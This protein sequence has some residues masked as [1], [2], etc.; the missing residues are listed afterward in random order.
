MSAKKHGHS[1]AGETL[2]HMADVSRAWEGLLE[3]KQVLQRIENKMDAKCLHRT[4]AQTIR[5]RRLLERDSFSGRDSCSSSIINNPTFGAEQKGSWRKDE[6]FTLDRLPDRHVI[7]FSSITDLKL[8]YSG[9]N[10]P[11]DSRLLADHPGYPS[12]IGRIKTQDFCPNV[13]QDGILVERSVQMGDEVPFERLSGAF[14]SHRSTEDM[15]EDVPNPYLVVSSPLGSEYPVENYVHGSLVVAPIPHLSPKLDFYSQKLDCLKRNSPNGKLEKLKERIRE[16]KRRLNALK[17]KPP[18]SWQTTGIMGKHVLKR[19]VAFAPPPHTYKD[20]DRLFTRDNDR[21][22]TPDNDRLFTRDND[23]LFTPDN[24]RL[25]T[26]DIDR[27]FSRDNDRLFTPDNNRLFTRDNDRLFSRDNDRLFTR[28]NDRLFSR[29]NDRLFTRD[30]DRL[31]TRD[32]D[33]LFTRDNDRLFT[34]DI[35]RLFTRDND[36][37]FTRDI[38]RL[39]TRDNDRL[40]TRDI[41]R[42]FTRDIDRLFTRDIDRLFTR[43]NDRLFTRD[44]DRLFTRDIDR[45]F[46]RDNDRLFTRDN[47]KLFTRDN[48]VGRT[49]LGGLHS[50]EVK[51]LKEECKKDIRASHHQIFK[52]ED[53]KVKPRP[54]SRSLSFDAPSPENKLRG[55]D[56][57]KASAWRE[58]QKLVR[59]LLG[60][61]PI[62]AKKP[63][64]SPALSMITQSPGKCKNVVVQMQEQKG[65]AVSNGNTEGLLQPCKSAHGSV[66]VKPNI[67]TPQLL[68]ELRRT[69]QDLPK[70]GA[71]IPGNVAARSR[72]PSP[73]KF[74]HDVGRKA[75]RQ[76]DKE[77]VAQS[78]ERQVQGV[79]NRSYS[80]EEVRNF[81]S[82]KNAERLRREREERSVLQKAAHLRLK[83]L[84]DVIQ[85]QKSAFPPRTTS[86]A[87]AKDVHRKPWAA[88]CRE[89]DRKGIQEW[90][91]L[92]TSDLLKEERSRELTNQPT[93]ET[94]H[95]EYSSPLKLQD[96]D[97]F[98]LVL[99]N[100]ITETT[101]KEKTSPFSVPASG[102]PILAQY[103]ESQQRLKDIFVVAKE[104]G[105]R[106]ELETSRIGGGQLH[107]ASPSQ[108][109]PT[110]RRIPNKFGPTS[111]PTKRMSSELVTTLQANP[112]QPETQRRATEPVGQTTMTPAVKTTNKSQDLPV[113]HGHTVRDI[114]T[115]P[116]P[117][118]CYN[119]EHIDYKV[120]P[121]QIHTKKT[122]T[123]KPNQS[124]SSRR[125]LGSLEGPAERPVFNKPILK[126]DKICEEKQR[127][128]KDI[129]YPTHN[130]DSE[131]EEEIWNQTEPATDSTSKWSEVSEF[132]GSPSMFS[133]Y[134]LE[135][136]QQ[137][138]REEELRARH[139]AALLRLR[140]EA[141]K[142]KA[143]AELA[144]LQQQRKCLEMKN[145]QS[146]MADLLRQEREIQTNLRQEQAEIRHLHSVYKAAQRERKLLLKQQKE[147]LQIQQTAAHIH[148]QLRDSGATRQFTGDSI[149]QD[150]DFLCNSA[151]LSE[152]TNP[153]T[154]SGLSDLLIDDTEC[155]SDGHHMSRNGPIPDDEP[156]A[157]IA[158]VQKDLLAE[159]PGLEHAFL[160]KNSKI[161]ESHPKTQDGDEVCHPSSRVEEPMMETVQNNQASLDRDSPTSQESPD[162]HSQVRISTTNQESEPFVSKDGIKMDGQ[163]EKWPGMEY[164]INSRVTGKTSEHPNRAQN[165]DFGAVNQDLKAEDGSSR[166]LEPN[167]LQRIPIEEDCWPKTSEDASKVEAN[168][169]SQ[170][171]ESAEQ[172]SSLADFLKVS[173]KLVHI[174]ES[175]VSASDKGE[176]AQ[177]TES[178]DSEVFDMESSEIPY[179]AQFAEF[180][181]PLSHK[182]TGRSSIPDDQEFVETS[183]LSQNWRDKDM[184]AHSTG[185]SG[186]E[187]IGDK[188]EQPVANPPKRE[189]NYFEDTQLFWRSDGLFDCGGQPSTPVASSKNERK[190]TSSEYVKTGKTKVA[191]LGSE[192]FPTSSDFS[193]SAANTNGI[194]SLPKEKISNGARITNPQKLTKMSQEDI[195]NVDEISSPDSKD[196]QTETNERQSFA[197]EKLISGRIEMVP[198]QATSSKDLY[199]IKSLTLQCEENVTFITDEV[200]QPLEDTLSEIFS[201]VDEMLSYESAD[202]YSTK[203]DFSYHSEDL[204]SLP[205]EAESIKSSDVNS[206]DFPSPPEQIAEPASESIHSSLEGSITDELHLLYDILLTEDTF[207]PPPP[208]PPE[209]KQGIESGDKKTS[210]SPIESVGKGSRTDAVKMPT[211]Y[212][213]L[214][215]A[216]EDFNDPLFTFEIGDRVLV[217]LSKPGTLK[218][219][220]LT[221]FGEGYWAGVALDQA[222]GDHNGTYEGVAY[223]ECPLNCGVFVRPRQISH[224]LCDDKSISEDIAGGGDDD[225]DDNSFDQNS[226]MK[227]NGSYG[228]KE[229][230]VTENE[231]KDTFTHPLEAN[232]NKSKSCCPETNKCI[233]NDCNLFPRDLW[234]KSDDKEPTYDHLD[235][236]QRQRW[237]LRFSEDLIRRVMREAI[238][239]CTKISQQKT[240]TAKKEE[241]LLQIKVEQDEKH[242]SASASDPPLA[243]SLR[244]LSAKARGLLE[245]IAHELVSRIISDSIKEYTNLKR[246]DGTW[247]TIPGLI[248]AL[249]SQPT[250]PLDGT[251]LG[252]PDGQAESKQAGF[253]TILADSVRAIET[254]FDLL[255]PPHFHLQGPKNIF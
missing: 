218:F 26:R 251:T 25:F 217:K 241:C 110:N 149:D 41:D 140:E 177:D 168:E 180:E 111:S 221:S 27:L 236:N 78:K 127:K 173:A 204:P 207:L 242:L 57:Y 18:K 42:L 219:K 65:T 115:K 55:A 16:Q 9:E 116:Q 156:L 253:D 252:R 87:H 61:S 4:P 240:Q 222:V 63:S 77:N 14:M 152:Q 32:N 60:P 145:E 162:H 228:P 96:L 208:P 106:I 139:Q 226:T 12:N 80:V 167:D 121:A 200:L 66:C 24:N 244:T 141:I 31:F 92:Q 40:F 178:G 97:T 58:G 54:V 220:G 36:R 187:D 39:F 234:S 125:C 191:P 101:S 160:A 243:L 245:S 229:S 44:I 246:N 197:E 53:K 50:D 7:F 198:F 35:D 20:N 22:F 154:H 201:P 46:T 112:S 237:V 49:K 176:E 188:E 166:M 190:S 131:T 98:S 59:R 114:V 202:F 30:I 172:N 11:W 142:E 181:D 68:P 189:E 91:K 163:V 52:R 45:L 33:R 216:D 90:V 137:C 29:D 79:R 56:L 34:R 159:K 192:S 71:R 73:K 70:P 165:K 153:D 199:P 225:D 38:D 117:A 37:L 15:A 209:L 194:E 95:I 232:E 6:T 224:L 247:C 109:V 235:S 64:V 174:S 175:S 239:K 158:G 83:R 105:E 120:S 205:D 100:Y 214:S 179:E 132:Y 227:N 51:H 74:I 47:D 254:I 211:P 113:T 76:P 182:L 62:T 72:S 124:P 170:T 10:M 171:P 118:F 122:L 212:L 75:K 43:D 134:T 213:T 103:R 3:A 17:E 215:K 186:V 161:G 195:S 82:K 185:L 238:G 81:M 123:E 147:I 104:L 138:L 86:C 69:D 193:E 99:K 223:F 148:R 13:D 231:T 102:D 107:Q 129:T 183:T 157:E 93:P 206:E 169:R 119:T 130:A 250:D 136:A 151:T 155:A 230:K 144:F 184:L 255:C 23:R 146:K 48:N 1:P 84:Q 233:F 21:L 210:T 143:K 203:K 196:R 19:K 28:D 135:M 94:L 126:H 8:G 150:D 133:R 249:S 5:R 89:I 67:G 164:P 85:K 2:P 128:R 248:F 108:I 88:K